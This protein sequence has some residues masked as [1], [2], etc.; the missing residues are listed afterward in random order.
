MAITSNFVL[1]TIINAWRAAG[2]GVVWIYSSVILQRNVPDRFRG[3][4]FSFEFGM[5]TIGKN[6][7]VTLSN[8]CS[9][10]AVLTRFVFGLLEDTFKLSVPTIVFIYGILGVGIT[11]AWAV[12]VYR[13]NK[14]E[15]KKRQLNMES[16]EIQELML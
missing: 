15:A 12:G 5:L 14:K 4:T 9:I 16:E 8:M 10:A 7:M 13:K 11:V 2:S 1:F 3:R 6:T